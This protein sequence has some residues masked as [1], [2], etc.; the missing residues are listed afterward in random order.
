MPRPL[1][2]PDFRNPPIN[3]VVV[4]VQFVRL[5]ITGAHV[6]R[7]WASALDR[8]PRV[9]EQP[10]LDPQLEALGPKQGIA[11]LH[12]SIEPHQ[13]RHWLISSSDTE[14]LQLQSDR[15]LFNWRARPGAGPY[16]H[17]EAIHEKFRSEFSEWV[18]FLRSELKQK[19]Q[20]TQWEVT[21]VNSIGGGET[22]D[23]SEILSFIGPQLR[24]AIAGPPD[25]ARF[26]VQ[27]VLRFDDGA[28]WARAY[29][30][31]KNGFG[32][33]REP[34]VLL[35]LTVR[36]P[37]PPGGEESAI[38]ERHFQAREWIVRAFDA[39]TTDSQ[40]KTWGKI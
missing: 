36:G 38:Y 1:H 14:L 33:N 24:A 7:F 17:F 40:H 12:F 18:E 5:P 20:L 28:A 9:E 10:P 39:L 37:Q 3:E 22:P 32:P 8:Y 11:Q 29:V 31:A 16:P 35:E 30:S 2:L 4:G 25:A 21:Y 6:G 13:S 23:L 15:F 19:V 26:D 34:L 27:R